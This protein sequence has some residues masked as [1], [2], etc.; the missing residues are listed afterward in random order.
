MEVE[1]SELR[2]IE[3]EL[4]E[5]V[6]EIGKEIG[7]AERKYWCKQYISG[8]IIEGERKSIEPMSRRLVGGDEQALQQFVN[9]SPWKEKNIEKKLIEKMNKKI[10]SEKAVII[11]DDTTI[12]KKGN[13]SVGVSRQYCGALGKVANCQAIV[14]WHYKG[15]KGHYPLVAELYLPENWIEDSKKLELTGV[16]EAKR[17]FREKWKIALELLDNLPKEV[18]YQ[19][20]VADAGYGEIKEFLQELDKREKLFV[21]Q[22]PQSHSFWPE[23]VELI[24]EQ[25][26]F[27][28]PRKYPSIADNKA[29]A[30]SANDWKDKAIAENAQVL[31][32]SLPLKKKKK[33]QVIAYRVKETITQAWYRPGVERWLLIEILSDGSYKYYLSNAPKD[34]SIEQLVLWAHSRWHIEQG[35]QQMKEELGLDHFEGRSWRG[36]HHHLVLCFAAFDFLT[37]LTLEKKNFF[38]FSSS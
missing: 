31:T 22:I 16:P 21:V 28:R 10:G 11:L 9:Q 36:L 32:I 7:R 2:K 12:P 29:K 8:L 34:I 25:N 13:K 38:N 27:G 1:L 37:L 20:I 3:K 26:N 14:T 18:K 17:V 24:T 33:V 23:N 4:S 35:Y 15:E 19:A 30:L 6:E 5:F